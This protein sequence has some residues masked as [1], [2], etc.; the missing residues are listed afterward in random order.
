MIDGRSHRDGRARPG[1]HPSA[2]LSGE[3]TQ[4][5]KLAQSVNRPRVSGVDSPTVAAPSDR[6]HVE[7]RFAGRLVQTMACGP[8]LTI[9]EDGAIVVPG[10]GGAVALLRAGRVVPAAALVGRVDPAPVHGAIPEA[11]IAI[12]P[13]VRAV[14]SPRDFPQIE[15]AV[16]RLAVE[17]LARGLHWMPIPTR[18]TVIAAAMAGCLAA[19]I[20]GKVARAE[21]TEPERD[22]DETETAIVRAVHSATPIVREYVLP[23]V[24]RYAEPPPA[25]P[26]PERAPETSVTIAAAPE[27]VTPVALPDPE[28][29]PRKRARRRAR[30][31]DGMVV[32]M[33]SMKEID[34]IL[35]GIEGGALT[36]SYDTIAVL[37]SARLG[38]ALVHDGFAEGGVLRLRAPSEGGPGAGGLA[39]VGTGAGG[40]V[41]AGNRIEEPIPESGAP[42]LARARP[43]L[44]EVPSQDEPREAASPEPTVSPMIEIV[45]PA[46]VGEPIEATA[47]PEVP[48]ADPRGGAFDMD[49]ALAG[50]PS[51]AADRPGTLMAVIETSKGT[52]RCA[53]HEARAPRTVANFVGLARGVRESLPPGGKAW[54]RKRFYDGLTFHR[55]V[56]GFVIQG[57][58][59]DGRGSGGPGYTFADEIDPALSHDAPGVLSMANRGRDTNGSQFFVTLAPAKHIDG[60]S[61]IFGKCDTDVAQAI[62]KVAVEPAKQ[63]RP[64]EPVRIERVTI[65]RE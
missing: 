4:R 23:P 41:H 5:R 30:A 55:V 61:T 3:A 10:L 46:D 44:R 21:L 59:P 47:E 48:P 36:S 63:H 54:Q 14:V 15:I 33:V 6:F 19:M 1:L 65:V 60:T 26:E 53:L 45:P 11:G 34:G 62:G 12:D 31:R 25:P 40:D 56:D 28:A 9:G 22:E 18:E 49:D 52:M 42:T 8:E 32:E 37:D 20:G 2:T 43:L 7:V 27:I 51:L 58:D 57:G 39:I 29:K 50:D 35:G 13:G 16:E 17:P 38:D 64:V 24:V